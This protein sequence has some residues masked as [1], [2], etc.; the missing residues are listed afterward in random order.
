MLRL[1]LVFF[2][3][4]KKIKKFVLKNL[5]LIVFLLIMTM[6]IILFRNSIKPVLWNIDYF[7]EKYIVGKRNDTIT[8]IM[9]VFS[10]L[11]SAYV[12]IPI[13][14]IFLIIDKFKKKSI[15][16]AS[17]LTVVFLF[18]LIIKTIVKRER[19]MSMII[20]ERGYSFPSG[21]ATT[22]MAFYG[23]LLYLVYKYI[24][25][26][27]LKWSICVVLGLLILFIGFSRIYL[28]AH[29]FSDVCGGFIIGICYLVIL[30]KIFNFKE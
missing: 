20:S 10:F 29:Y 6:F 17:N 25:N 15:F 11:G 24:K 5:F 9:K 1:D 16:V 13:A 27:A 23:F 2:V 7:V 30:I 12:L 8:I 22:N 4:M 18:N 19:P 3:I 21:H 26:K 14:I 28:G